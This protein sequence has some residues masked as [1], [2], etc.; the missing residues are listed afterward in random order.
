M[1][2]GKHGET[3][4]GPR[5]RGRSQTSPTHSSA[6]AF[7]EVGALDRALALV[8]R[9][10]PDMAEAVL[11]R[12]VADLAVDEVAQVMG[13]R[14]GHV[15]V[16]VHRGLRKLAEEL[17]VTDEPLDNDQ[18]DCDQ[19]SARARQG[20][21]S[22]PQRRA[23]PPSWRVRTQRRRRW[24]RH[25]PPRRPTVRSFGSARSF[26]VV[27][28]VA[29]S[30][31]GMG[32]IAAAGAATLRPVRDRG[33]I[34][35]AD[36]ATSD[37]VADDRSRRRSSTPRPPRPPSPTTTIPADHRSRRWRRRAAGRRP[38]DGVRRDTVRRGQP[39]RHRQLD[40]QGD[41]PGSRPR[42]RGQRSPPTPR[43]ARTRP[44]T[45]R[46]TTPSA[47]TLVDDPATE[48]DETQCAE[49]NHGATVSSIAKET[50]PGPGHGDEVSSRRPLLV[51]QERRPTT[52]RPTTRDGTDT[53]TS[54]RPMTTPRA[55]APAM[56][57]R[58]AT[59]AA[60]TTRAVTATD[61]GTASPAAEPEGTG[62]RRSADAER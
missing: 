29:A 35:T 25:S 50:P 17:A 30:L 8:R 39:R 53:T 47:S 34:S 57:I 26:R 62:A 19:R 22:A 10:P 41:P 1:P 28:V 12:V 40:R 24:P 46:P 52:T 58:T 45:T 43:A 9:L 59:A 15:R 61:A 14:E 56:A 33:E 37:I 23:T 36:T 60:T 16:L 4:G 49:G 32:G 21:R 27:A 7:D 13:R 42:R 20:H 3:S 44:T 11:L 55:T 38:G 18:H 48:F 5:R 31:I 51:R 54:P 6:R 2:H